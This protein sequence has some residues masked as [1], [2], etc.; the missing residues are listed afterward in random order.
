MNK[1]NE[2]IHFIPLNDDMSASEMATCMNLIS[3][4]SIFESISNAYTLGYTRGA[5]SLAPKVDIEMIRLA[6]GFTRQQIAKSL[7][8][9]INRYNSIINGKSQMLVNE[10]VMIHEKFNI[11]FENIAIK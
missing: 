8:I 10:F 4:G 6:K 5:I 3:N 11:P 9:S 7:G 2:I 1:F